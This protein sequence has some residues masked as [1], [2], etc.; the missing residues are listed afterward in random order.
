[1]DV[2]CCYFHTQYKSSAVTNRMGFI[3]KLPLMLSFYEHAAVRIGRGYSLFYS[4]ST[5]GR[6][7][8]IV[9]AVIFNGF[10]SQFLPFC[11]HLSAQLAGV[12]LC[13]L[14]HL[15][16]LVLFLVGA[17][18]DVCTINKHGAGVYHTVIQRFIENMLKDFSSQFIRETLAEGIAHRGKMGN[19][20]QKSISQKPTICQIDLNFSVCL[21]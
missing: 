18:F 8:L 3:G 10:L 4:S 14:L 1:M 17:G 7:R 2:A 19:L 5:G 6:L 15:F 11:V 21:A 16:L 9:I 20:V 13:C 12:Y